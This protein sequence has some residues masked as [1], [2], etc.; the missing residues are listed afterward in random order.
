MVPM[1]EIFSKYQNKG[2]YFNAFV[3]GINNK[4]AFTVVTKNVQPYPV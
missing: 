3:P 2:Q 4:K 1:A